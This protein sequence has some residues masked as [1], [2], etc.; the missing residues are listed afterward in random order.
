MLERSLRKLHTLTLKTLM[1]WLH[2]G[3]NMQRWSYDLSTYILFFSYAKLIYVIHLFSLL[4]RN[5]DKAIDVM[6]RATVPPRNP[7][8][9][10]A[11]CREKCRSRWSM[12]P[13]NKQVK[14]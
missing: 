4:K 14:N 7:K 2:C 10:R 1:T 9:G 5:Y 12:C 8:I 11:S 3:V 6:G 13:E